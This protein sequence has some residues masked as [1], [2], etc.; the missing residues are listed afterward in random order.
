MKC[1]TIIT[2]SSL[3]IIL[4]S[5]IGYNIKNLIYNYPPPEN[6]PK[7]SYQKIPYKSPMEDFIKIDE[8]TLISCGANFKDLYF[9]FSIY[10]P[11]YKLN[12]GTLVLFDIKTK[13]LKNLEL[14]NFPK[15]LNF[16]PHGM[17]LYKNK[18]IYV[19]NHGLNSI[20][21]ERIEIFEIIKKNNDIEYLNYIKSIKLSEEF[22]STTNGL[23]VV[24][25]D[26]IF[27][28]KSFPIHPP[29][30]DKANFFNK[31]IPFLAIVFNIVLNLKMTNLYHYKNGTITKVKDSKSG[32]NNGVAY[33]PVNRLIFLAQTIENNIRVFKY[34]ENGEIIFM[35]DIYLGYKIDNVI[36][37]EKNRILSA[38]II[39]LGGYGGL[40]EIY[41]DKNFEIKIPFYDLIGVN[42]SSALKINNKIYIV[43]PMENYLLLCEII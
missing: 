32:F 36:F 4:I 17:E 19:I 16:F 26:D 20:D 30:M 6:I 27:F 3:I 18:Y 14:R 40:A 15:N 29:A 31:K 28:S 43:T 10:N 9:D 11:G 35:R 25:E 13:Q 21:G 8:N 2:I 34:K 12:Q 22:L 41:P 1:S 5:Y 42:L 23:A 38:G 39:G 37:D 33:D 7:Y 24:E